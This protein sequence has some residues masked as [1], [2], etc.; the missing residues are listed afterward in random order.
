MSAPP[1]ST[2]LVA[3]VHEVDPDDA[4]RGS[5]PQGF[6]WLH[7]DTADRDLGCRGA[8]S[9]VDDVA[10]VLAAIDGRRRV[11]RPGAP[12]PLAVGALAFD[13]DAPGELVIPAVVG[14]TIGGA[15]VRHADR[16]RAPRAAAPARASDALHDRRAAHA[17]TVDRD[18][19]AARSPR[20]PTATSRRSCSHA[21]CVVEADAPFDARVP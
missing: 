8:A 16:A 12:A 21:R 9:R 18:G 5:T 14:T 3:A 15:P 6:A 7:H 10:A 17:R 19:R 13:P 11:R 1:T 20:S 4:R 2:G